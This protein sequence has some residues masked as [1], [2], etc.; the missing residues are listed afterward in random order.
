MSQDG[1]ENENQYLAVPQ[2]RPR[3]RLCL[4]YRV[5]MNFIG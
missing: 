5:R 3:P 4:G 1:T 2:F